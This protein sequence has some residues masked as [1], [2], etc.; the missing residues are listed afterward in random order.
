MIKGGRQFRCRSI[1]QP[2]QAKFSI[3][4]LPDFTP[5]AKRRFAGR[6]H[7]DVSFANVDE[8]LLLWVNGKLVEFNAPTTYRPFATIRSRS[9]AL[10]VPGPTAATDL[11]AGRHR[12][13]RWR[14]GEVS[15]LKIWR[16]IYY[17]ADADHDPGRFVVAKTISSNII[18]LQADQFF[19]MGD[20]SP[21]AADSRYWRFKFVDRELLIGKALFIYWPHSWHDRATVGDCRNRCERCR[22]GR[23]SNG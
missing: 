11:V 7:I 15:H 1:W 14:G 5:T 6:E 17:T 9:D 4:G 21:Q 18:D 16:D 8:Q 2:A 22:S 19:M 23:I 13:R 12:R 10:P 20:N 3:S